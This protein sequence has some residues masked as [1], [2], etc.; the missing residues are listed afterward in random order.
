MMDDRKAL[1]RG[2]IL[3]FQG[4]SCEIGEEI[5]RGS[6]ALVYEGSYKDALEQESLHRILVKELFPLE[7]KGKIWRQKDGHI[8]VEPEAEETF[9]MH[10]ESF[11]A[12]NRAHL[13][14]LEA[15]PG[16]IGANLNTYR[17]NGTLYSLLGLSGGESLARI[18]K[19]PARSLRTLASRM[20][21][22][23][24]ALYV[25]HANGLA[26]LDIAPDNILLL[27][28][29]R[30]ERALL[31]DYNSAMAVDISRRKDS[32]VFSVKQ[33][34][35]APEVRAGR[36]KDIG[37]ASDMYSVTAVFYWMITGTPLTGFQMI[38]ALPPDVSDFPCLKDEPQTVKAWVREILRRG[39]QTIPGRRYQEAASLRRDLLEL[40][41]RIDG[42]GITHWALWE[43][44]R[45]QVDRLV[46]ENPSLS[47]IRDS[48]GLFPLQV[49]DGKES[50]P[51]E[52]YLRNGRENYQ[53]VAGGGMGKTT[54][55]L[56][57]VFS[58]EE[59]YAPDR[60]AMMY[61]SLYGWQAGD[62]SYIV[63][64]LLNG[65]HFRPETHT[66]EDARK[67]LY[68]LLDRPVETARGPSPVLMLLLD[69]LNEV[70]GDTKGLLDEI[71]S[72]SSLRG[73]RLMVATRTAEKVLDFSHL[74]LTGLLESTVKEALSREGMLLPEKPD[75]QALLQTPMMLSLYL[76]SGQM[77]K[78]QI[79][80][81]N[82][83]ELLDTYLSALKEK[84]VR[85]LPEQTDIRWQIDAASELLLPAIAS[86]IHKKQRGLAD[87]ELLPVAEKCYRLLNGRLS[88]R[89][90][91]QWIGRTAA[92][93]GDA[94]NAEEWYGQVVHGILWKMLGLIVRDEQGRYVIAHQAIEEHLLLRDEDNR[95]RVRTYHMTRSL[96]IAVCAC[97][98]VLSSLA[99]Y[100]VY[101]APQP[102]DEGYADNVMVRALGAYVGAGKQ[103][104][105]LSDL[106]ADAVNDPAS[107]G[108][109]LELFE[110]SDLY[111]SMPAETSLLYLSA[112]LETGKVMPW[113]HKPMDE[114]AC[115]TLLA[116]PESR[117]EEY[118]L[119]A[120]VLA[121]VMEDD[122][123]G[124]HYGGQYPELLLQLLET[125]ADIA[126]ELYQ[127]VCMPHLSGKYADNSAT[128]GS[129]SSLF[130]SVSR[131]NG[132]LTGENS[133]QSWESLQSL[134]G[135]RRGQLLRLYQCGAFDA[136]E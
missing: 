19:G 117:G 97:L 16:Q 111:R 52:D 60:P 21:S 133:R 32:A 54:S 83:E 88:R 29:G 134:N 36:L 122:Y 103:Y 78:K 3:N 35:T 57:M 105:L 56:H 47:F 14:L 5:G 110:N 127:I 59:R 99:V 18:Q 45:R 6:N 9:R 68:E 27:G 114:E 85:D 96:I 74:H 135:K 120:S 64:S 11:E 101:V 33:G 71:N 49:S 118:Q 107:F 58:G 8:H 72:L 65:L 44:G 100:R 80:A 30:E 93:R 40:M 115:R 91:P 94:G 102:Y 43:N 42:V 81:K 66:F 106:A 108:Q 24:D 75:M 86:E 12:G 98:A 129:Y 116:L 89:F 128:A 26:H 113:S 61:L 112:M 46:R 55:L 22:I 20:L 7:A 82:K 41:D 13:A 104:E 50:Y 34:Y 131:Q 63:D 62:R 123:A 121:F 15:C 119:F 70:P 73:V 4:L 38:R 39:L 95:R 130:S 10:R 28:S 84:A 31:I 79:R 17:M 37:F 132:H 69:G 126:A 48:A 53:L 2:T 76:R 124:R 136:Y 109:Q 67:A 51:A 23:L 90:F 1:P 92:I 125:D 77:D 25:F 87:G